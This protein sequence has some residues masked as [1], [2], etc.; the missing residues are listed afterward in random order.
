LRKVLGWAAWLAGSAGT[1]IGAMS[2]HI[3]MIVLCVAVTL[4][5]LHFAI[6]DDKITPDTMDTRPPA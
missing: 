4:V 2:G 5:G 1:I 6:R 3:W